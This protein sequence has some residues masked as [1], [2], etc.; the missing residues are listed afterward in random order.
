M[1]AKVTGYSRAQVALHWIVLVLVAFQFLAHDGIEKAWRGFRSGQPTPTDA[2]VLTNMH[3]GA[4]TLVLMLALL[5]IYL[6]LTRGAPP[7]PA[8][9][10]RLLQ[11]AAEAVHLLI[12]ALLIALPLSGAVAWFAGVA[13][14]AKVHEWLTNA[15]LGAIA[16]HIGGALF[17]HFVRRSDVLM[18]MLSP[19]RD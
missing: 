19:Q 1:A 7:P 13:A 17:Q 3:I 6:R 18:R 14:S 8:D 4:G 9:E 11:L 15:L 16:V 10:P 2:A 12:Y 5:R